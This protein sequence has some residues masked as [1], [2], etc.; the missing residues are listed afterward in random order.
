MIKDIWITN[1]AQDHRPVYAVSFKTKR[2]PNIPS[3]SLSEDPFPKEDEIVYCL[4]NF[5]I[6]EL[7]FLRQKIIDV[8]G[9]D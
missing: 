1:M 5:S 6:D 7:K 9:W 4:H 8:I 2:N 3:L